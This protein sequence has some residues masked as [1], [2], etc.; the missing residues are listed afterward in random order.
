MW[1]Q[2]DRL[3]PG[4]SWSGPGPGED[5]SLPVMSQRP[6]HGLGAAQ[7]RDL[8]IINHRNKISERRGAA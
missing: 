4:G 5:L 8:L 6:P 1:H 7:L 3:P 2:V